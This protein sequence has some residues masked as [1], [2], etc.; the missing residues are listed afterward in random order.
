MFA[1]FM[2]SM[3]TAMHMQMMELFSFPLC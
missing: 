2:R 1:F 3:Y